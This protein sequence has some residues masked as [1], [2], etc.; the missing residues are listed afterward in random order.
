MDQEPAYW[1]LNK[2]AKPDICEASLEVSVAW[3]REQW[4]KTKETG[5][6]SLL[7]IWVASGK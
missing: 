1:L 3:R 5:G 4:A 6:R 2:L 7:T